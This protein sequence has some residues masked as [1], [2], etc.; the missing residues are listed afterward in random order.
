MRT[1]PTEKFIAFRDKAAEDPECA[2]CL[3]SGRFVAADGGY[4]TP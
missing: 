1:H 2:Q 3:T 4:K